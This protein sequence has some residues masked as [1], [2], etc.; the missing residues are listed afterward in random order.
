MSNN[1][2]NTNPSE[3]QC[4]WCG[5]STNKPKFCSFSC[6]GKYS[7][8]IRTKEFH[9]NNAQKVSKFYENKRN[10]LIEEY[11]KNPKLCKL[12]SCSKPIPYK[13]FCCHSCAAT[14]TNSTREPRSAESRKKTAIASNF[15]S[16]MKKNAKN[17]ESIF[18]IQLKQKCEYDHTRIIYSKIT[19]NFYNPEIHTNTWR[20]NL[21]I[22]SAK[23]LS[24]MFDFKLKQCETTEQNLIKA[25]EQLEYLYNEEK[26]SSE[27]IMKMFNISYSNFSTWLRDSLGIKMRNFTDSRNISNLKQPIAEKT[28]YQIYK[29]SCQ[30]KF[31]LIEMNKLDLQKAT[32]HGWYH[33]IKNPNGAT[34]DHMFSIKEG[35][36]QNIPPELIKHPANCEIMLQKENSSKNAKCSITL[37]ELKQRIENWK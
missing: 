15:Y 22:A 4:K 6:Q 9:T 27:D 5:E 34:R 2:Y 17:D 23:R 14:Y 35:F 25:T 29:E 31:T 36:L 26:M 1:I 8:S 11:N 19:G 37:E 18:Y 3:N 24:E 13:K 16:F 10:D 20:D 30:F 7:N 21:R 32:I 28:E 12:E 33:P